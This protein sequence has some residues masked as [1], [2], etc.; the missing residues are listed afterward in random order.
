MDVVHAFVMPEIE[1]DY[2]RKNY[3]NMEQTVISVPKVCNTGGGYGWRRLDIIEKWNKQ[4]FLA[5][6]DNQDSNNQGMKTGNT[7]TATSSRKLWF[8]TLIDVIQLAFKSKN[9]CE[10]PL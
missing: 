5:L 10:E 7:Q 1:F 4:Q 9:E 2:C 8:W 3:F 6:W